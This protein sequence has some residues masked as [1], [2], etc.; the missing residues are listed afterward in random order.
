MTET[1]IGV[2]YDI[3]QALAE[4]PTDIKTILPNLRQ[5]IDLREQIADLDKQLSARKQELEL[6]LIEHHKAN[7]VDA[8]TGGGVSVS[9]DPTA[10][11]TTYDPEKFESIFRW[12]AETGHTYLIQRRFTDAK[13]MALIDDGVALPEGLGVEQYVKLNVR[14]K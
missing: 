3:A 9:F 6:K 4:V 5:V 8:V 14:R 12:C 1:S 10:M 13:V 7:G 11:R 2:E